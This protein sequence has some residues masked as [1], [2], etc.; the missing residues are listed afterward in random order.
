[1]HAYTH[2]QEGGGSRLGA[3]VGAAAATPLSIGS[4]VKCC[5][6]LRACH[7]WTPY[8]PRR[9]R[10]PTCCHN[11]YKGRPL[12][13]VQC[14]LFDCHYRD[15]LKA[16]AVSRPRRRVRAKARNRSL[17]GMVKTTQTLRSSRW[18]TRRTLPAMSTSLRRHMSIGRKTGEERTG[19]P[20]LS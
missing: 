3:E 1:M 16:I 6:Q 19:R 4:P 7:A 12:A 11:K 5:A 14:I 15:V 20:Q 9:H 17:R 13:R 8:L 2:V 18:N 10:L